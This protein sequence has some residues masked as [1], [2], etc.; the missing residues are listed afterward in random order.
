MPEKKL[1]RKAQI[2]WAGIIAGTGAVVTGTVI[3]LVEVIRKDEKEMHKDENVINDLNSKIIDQA[4]NTH[5]LIDD[6]R[7]K[8]SDINKDV[9]ITHGKVASIESAINLI[10]RVYVESQG[11]QKQDTHDNWIVT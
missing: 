1:K 11:N 6:I 4:T 2:K 7:K 3:P 9:G 10:M 8:L 5:N